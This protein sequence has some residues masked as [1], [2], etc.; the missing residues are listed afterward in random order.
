MKKLEHD[1]KSDRFTDIFE[2]NFVFNAPHTYTILKND[3]NNEIKE[4]LQKIHFQEG[5]TKENE[6]NGIF[7]EDLIYICINR[8]EYFQ[9]SNFKCHENVCAITKLE[10]ALMW[11]RKRTEGR[12]KRGIFGTNIV[13]RRDACYTSFH[14]VSQQ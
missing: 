12:K 3:P 10:E 14:S 6:L 4:V 11:L 2:D 1:L 9:T 5:P 7:I 13:S 8:L